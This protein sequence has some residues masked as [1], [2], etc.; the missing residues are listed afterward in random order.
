MSLSDRLKNAS[1]NSKSIVC[2]VGKL[3]HTDQ[4]SQKDKDY[5]LTVLDVPETDPTRVT[6]ASLA[7]V[8]REEGFDISD[9]SVDRHR[10]KDCACYRKITK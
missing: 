8:L 2:K 6:N 3:L 9:S 1:A 4:L 10:R 7:R 5:L